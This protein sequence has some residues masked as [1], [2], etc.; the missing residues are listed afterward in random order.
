MIYN[1][2]S[3]VYID[4]DRLIEGRITSEGLKEFAKIRILS[5][6]LDLPS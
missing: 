1:V 6:T 3:D 2:F 4:W 5:P